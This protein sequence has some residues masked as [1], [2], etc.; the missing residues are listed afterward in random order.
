MVCV[1]GAGGGG[2]EWAIW[3]RVLGSRGYEVFAPDLVAGPHGLAATRF[4]DYRA[5]VLDWCRGMTP[6]PVLVGASLGGLLALTVVRDV[7]ASALV[8][9][10]PLQPSGLVESLPAPT[11]VPWRSRRTLASTR[12]AMPDADDA[13]RIHAFR[14]WRDESGAVLDEARAGVAIEAPTCPVLVFASEHD[15]DVPVESSCLLAATLEADF[16]QVAGASHV[17]PLLGR[18]AARTAE[19]VADWLQRRDRA[20]AAA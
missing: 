20:A 12:R 18:S 11:V 8:L 4:D 10:N 5:Q 13:A 3:A 6:A 1:H 17:G 14:R 19:R 15:T 7:Q 2:W 16:E 9:V